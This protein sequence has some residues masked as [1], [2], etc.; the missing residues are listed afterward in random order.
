[1]GALVRAS[2]QQ[3]ANKKENHMNAIRMILAIAAYDTSRVLLGLS[4]ALR[5]NGDFVGLRRVR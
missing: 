3:E 5:P 2:L 1:M 4:K